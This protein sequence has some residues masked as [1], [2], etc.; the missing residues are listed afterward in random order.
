[1]KFFKG[2]TSTLSMLAFFFIG[3]TLF[4]F[5]FVWFPKWVILHI[6]IFAFMN[7][8]IGVMITYNALVANNKRTVE[9]MLKPK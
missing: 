4:Y 9:N 8:G 3:N 2:L 6:I 5:S 7:F 1:M